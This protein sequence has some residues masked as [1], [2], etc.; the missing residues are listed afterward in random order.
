MLNEHKPIDIDIITAMRKCICKIIVE[1]KEN[2][3]YGTGFFMKISNT[4]K[5]LITNYHVIDSGTLNEKI[6]IEIWNKKKS[7]L[8]PNDFNI[9]FL[10]DP[11]DITA[12]KMTVISDIFEEV[13]FLNYDKNFEDGYLTY[14][15]ADVF[16]IE[17]P[18]G[19][20]AC[21]SSGKIVKIYN[22][23]FD[24][25]I[26]TDSGSSGC[27]ILLLNDNINLIKVI[28]IHKN[29]DLE[30]KINGGTFIGEII[31]E[32]KKNSQKDLNKNI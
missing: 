23:Q 21:C 30:K 3:S 18:L 9:I 4:E 7:V 2:F 12:F 15:N 19:K 1:T 13:E 24:H 20:K 17:H 31:N 32:I 29:G 8:N 22:F 27:P 28:G 26:A 11:K 14:K 5:Y 6:E 25:N 16:T 10:E